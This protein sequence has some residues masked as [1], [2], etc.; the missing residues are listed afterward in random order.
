MRDISIEKNSKTGAHPTYYQL[1]IDGETVQDPRYNKVAFSSTIWQDLGEHLEPF[2]VEDTLITMMK[3]KV[4][5]TDLTLDEIEEVC[6]QLKICRRKE[7]A[8]KN[9]I[10]K[11]KVEILPTDGGMFYTLKLDGKFI[12]YTTFDADMFTK[13]IMPDDDHVKTIFQSIL[14]ILDPKV[15]LSISEW[16]DIRMEIIKISESLK[17]NQ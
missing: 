4:K 10:H 11:R 6:N 12:D 7:E 3:W 13:D 8:L 15:T 14:D 2:M 17:V 1:L 16:Y 5:D 9:S